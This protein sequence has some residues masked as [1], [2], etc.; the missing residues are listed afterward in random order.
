MTNDAATL[1]RTLDVGR[2]RLAEAVTERHYELSPE[3]DARYGPAG[4]E[5]CLQ[6]A[7]FHLS[8]LA[9]AL[10]ASSPSLFADYVAWAKVML[11]ARGVPSKDLAKNL[12]VLGDVLVAQ[13]PA[14][15][16]ALARGYV[17]EALRGLPDAA[18][19][20]PSFVDEAAPHG[21]LARDYLERLLAGDRH[22]ASRL[23]LDA[24]ASGTRVADIYLGVFQPVQHEIGRL[25]QL[26]RLSVA[27][28]HFCTAAT[29]LVMSQLYPMIFA[30]EKNGYS[31]VATCVTG[32][33]H[34]IGMRMVSDFFEME[35][36]STYYLG[37]NTPAREVVGALVDRGGDVLAISAT[38]TSHVRDVAATIAAVRAE[39]ACDRVRIVV[40]GY[41]FNVDPGLWRRVGAD[42]M[43]A[44]A[45]DAIR[46]AGDLVATGGGR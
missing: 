37:A 13:L 21:A 25:W 16:G 23:V 11:A 8:Y 7:E 24:V 36:W 22:A 12:A 31:L 33:M 6:D 43:A 5:K 40:G 9:E 39:P 41:P 45:A 42:A 26:N 18:E 34:E 14:A 27:Q 19:S 10:A 17:E 44:D 4:R 20:L 28:E 30:G 1:S 2:R 15:D 32:D 29:Q 46:L 38:I 3:L 35:G